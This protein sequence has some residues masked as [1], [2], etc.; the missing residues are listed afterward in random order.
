M[1]CGNRACNLDPEG[2]RGRRSLRIIFATTSYSIR[3][4]ETDRLDADQNLSRIG[5]WLRNFLIDEHIRP[6]GRVEPYS[7]HFW[8]LR[9]Q[10]SVTPTAPGL[11]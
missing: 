9:F 1:Q 5:L 11:T 10:D 8:T 6:A 3:I 7:F 4:I 2:E